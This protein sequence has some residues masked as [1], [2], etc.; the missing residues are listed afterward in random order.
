MQVERWA[1]K[2]STRVRRVRVPTELLLLHATVVGL[3]ASALPGWG[4][5]NGV[6]SSPT[7]IASVNLVISCNK[8]FIPL[9]QR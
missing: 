8:V 1:C 2:K 7:N 6:C 5:Q 3:G 4:C 9:M